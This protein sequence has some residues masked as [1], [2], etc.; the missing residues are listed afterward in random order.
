M[1]LRPLAA[2]SRQGVLHMVRYFTHLMKTRHRR[3]LLDELP[4]SVNRGAQL[5]KIKLQDVKRAID[6][7][8]D[9]R[10]FVEPAVNKYGP[11]LI[12]WTQ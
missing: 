8:K 4:V 11:A 1:A 6:I 3:K 9:V 2:I 7:G 12:D 5:G 10:P